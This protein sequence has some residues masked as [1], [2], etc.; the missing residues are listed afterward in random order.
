MKR[1]ILFVLFLCLH[2]VAWGQAKY[3]YKYWFDNDERNMRTGTSADAAL[4]IDA[5]MAGLANQLHTIHLQVG[6]SK[7]IWS[8]P[9]TRH[10]LKMPVHNNNRTYQYWLDNDQK[11]MK[12]GEYSK[13]T[14]MLNIADATDGLHLLHLQANDNGHVSSP[15]TRMFI[16]VPQ[17]NGV[18]Y[19]TCIS[20]IDGKTYKQEKVNARGGIINWSLDVAELPQGLHQITVQVI[21]PSGAATNT[22][23]HFFFRNATKAE[24]DGMELLYNVD[25]KNFKTLKSPATNGVFHFDIDVTSIDEG[26][27]R[28]T[29]MLA[30]ETGTSTR[31]SSSFFVKI[32]IGGYGIA[33]YHYW[34]NENESEA[35]TVTFEKRTNPLSLVSL[36][37]VEN[38]PIR[39]SQFQFEVTD[40][41]PMLYAKN[42]IHFQFLDASNRLAETT[43]QY[44]DYNVMQEVNDIAT[45]E[46]VQTFAKPQ[47]N[48]IKWF[49]FYAKKGDS[50]AL[51][52]SMATTIELL[53]STGTTLYEAK[54]AESVQPGGTHLTKNGTYYVA[55]HDVTG[56]REDNI[57]LESQ[58]I[59]KFDLFGTSNANFGVM[60]CVQILDMEGNGFD[61]LKS[62][63]LRMDNN[64]IKVD[65]IAYK[66][67]ADARLYMMFDGKEEYG[68]YDLVLNFDDGEEQRN[69]TR[70]GY[71]TLSAPDFKGIDINITAPRSS[72]RPYP[73]SIK[74][75]N[76]SNISY[77]AIP[78]C[79]ALDN[80]DNIT[81]VDYLNFA[82]T[83]DKRLYE[84]GLKLNFEYD[85][86]RGNNTKTRVVPMI[87]PEL[88]PGESMTFDLGI[89]CRASMFKTYAWTGIPWNL[90]GP[91][92]A[93]F[94]HDFMSTP[95][96]K[97]KRRAVTSPVEDIF[98]GCGEDPCD[99]ASGFAEC[100]CATALS[101]G[102]TLGGIQ[103]ALQNRHNR[104]MRDQLAQ[105]GLFDDPNE[106]FPDHHLPSPGDLAWHWMEHCVHED[107]RDFAQNVNDIRQDMDNDANC[108]DPS[109]QNCQPYTPYDPN[110][111]HG[112]VSE[113]GSKY[114]MKEV[115]DVSYSVEFEND[116]EQATASAH[117]IEVTDTLD[118]TRFDLATFKPTAVRIGDKRLELDG[119]QNF[120]KTIDMRP[121]I[122]AIAQV[123]LTYDAEAGIAKWIISSL[124]PMT[125]EETYD[126]M[127]GVLPVNSN[128]NGIGFLDFDISLKKPLN[129]GETFSNRAAIVFDSN[130]PIIT[131][132][133]INTVD[134]VA[135]ESSIT[136]VEQ[137]EDTVM[138]VFFDGTDNRSGIWKYEV[139]VQENKTSTWRRFAECGAD[140]SYVEFYFKE[141]K[142]YGFCVI[143]TD[144][145]GNVEPKILARPG[146][147]DMNG[148]GRVDIGDVVVIRNVIAGNFAE[149][150]DKADMN[151]DGRVDIG[152]C[153][154]ILSIMTNGNKQQ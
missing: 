40:G 9:V 47:D 152:D 28:L 59:N 60:P 105:S 135:P 21:S 12:T 33:S 123:T 1:Y 121:N 130:E 32:P 51:K 88:L 129:D 17:T 94:I 104:A 68:L 97:A 44:V 31:M 136:N 96:A 132:T 54:G 95:A 22:S 70:K 34:F 78:F 8:V 67:K 77:Q 101:L 140:S 71:V 86:F 65:S 89:R 81:R 149:L 56:S 87:I 138:T 29:Y 111:M 126:F 50:I 62:A 154:R 24:I 108:H 147:G 107:L 25:G 55:I 124:D 148:D 30:S 93:M 90:K 76:K 100:N 45:L 118:A 113:A 122:N 58:L 15:I 38:C 102:G 146:E 23:D 26:I 3:K 120:V 151:G 10:F 119:K 115:S 128:G 153:V 41:K 127:Q 27:H 125:M 66:N 36:I 103:L 142:D 84:N 91:E 57:R 98:N 72:I 37:P 73:V 110:E 35:K 75:T 48:T 99:Y 143:A 141:K 112:Y 117:F 2:W 144:S 133:W 92:A 114:I 82:V 79:F 4:H 20:S 64:V 139:Y 69:I 74:L 13:G 52:S 18:D 53:D 11:N 145:A 85:N 150:K 80:M 42:D 19:L 61:N 43:K 5:D 137:N 116:P 16:K 7:G 106:Y 46:A 39:S 109:S 83:C 134:A 6:N 63:F 49:K 14:I 131:P